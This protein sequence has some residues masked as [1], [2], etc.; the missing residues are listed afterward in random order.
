MIRVYSQEFSLL[1]ILLSITQWRVEIGT[2]NPAHMTRFI[3]EKSLRVACLYS[4]FRFGIRFVF[5]VPMLFGRDDIELNL[6]LKKKSSCYNFS[7]CLS[8]LNSITVH[9]F[10]RIDLTQAYDTI[11]QCEV[12]FLS[13]S[14][15]DASLS[16]NNDN[17]NIHGYKLVRADYLK[18][19]KGDS[20][21][22][23][24]CVCFKESVP[25]RCL[26][27]SYL[28]KYFIFEVT[29]GSKIGYVV[30][31]YLSPSQTYNEFDSFITNLQKIV[32]NIYIGVICLLY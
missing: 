13:E 4:A 20:V 19:V 27:N 6:S 30:S 12:I 1:I 31:L 10:A 7:V 2:F 15:L 3:N 11:H 16:F 23:C 8:N 14:Y 22:V 18:N 29:I 24:V 5:L 32:V 25:V 17:L 21:C 26:P 28:K 9:N